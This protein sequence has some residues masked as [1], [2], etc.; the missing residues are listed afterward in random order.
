MLLLELAHEQGDRKMSEGKV[1]AQSDAGEVRIEAI[2]DGETTKFRTY[3]RNSLQP[4][5]NLDG[6]P[7]SKCSPLGVASYYVT[8]VQKHLKKVLTDKEIDHKV[9]DELVA[10]MK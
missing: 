3:I 10:D 5:W 8:S 7:A 9:I 2:S 1:I 4:Q 6:Q